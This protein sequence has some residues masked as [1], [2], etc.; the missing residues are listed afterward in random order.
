MKSLLL[1][2]PYE[3]YW[4]DKV[5]GITMDFSVRAEGFEILCADNRTMKKG[6]PQAE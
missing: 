4:Y 2:Y 6:C 1:D 3:L 5:Q